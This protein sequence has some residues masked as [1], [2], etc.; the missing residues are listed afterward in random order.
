MNPRT[1]FPWAEIKNLN[2]RDKKFCI[3][4]TDKVSKNFIFYVQN[5]KTNK[6]ILKLGIGY[7]Q[8]YVRK[9]QPETIEMKQMR[10]KAME[11]RN[12]LAEQR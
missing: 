8:L 12:I 5:P 10:A 2:F 3:K 7:H 6:R 11:R 9:R 4:P 1:T